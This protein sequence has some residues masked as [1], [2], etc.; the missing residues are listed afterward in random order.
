MGDIKVLSESTPKYVGVA[1]GYGWGH[2][3]VDG[4]MVLM[5]EAGLNLDQMEAIARTFIAVGMNYG[6]YIRTTATIK[7]NVWDIVDLYC[8]LDITKGP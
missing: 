7:E 3:A 8:K 2:E 1:G 6:R 5:A 4:S